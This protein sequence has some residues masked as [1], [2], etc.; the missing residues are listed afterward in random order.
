MSFFTRAKPDSDTIN[1]GNA[2][3]ARCNHDRITGTPCNLP[4]L[5]EDV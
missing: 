5:T 1:P 3:N 2:I 4:N